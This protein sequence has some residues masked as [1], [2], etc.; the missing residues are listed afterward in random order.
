MDLSF[1][2]DQEIFRTEVRDFLSKN[3]DSDMSSKMKLGIIGAGG[4]GKVVG[5]IALSLNYNQIF[6]FDDIN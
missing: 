1:S 5:D 6:Y 3:L 2:K 4:H